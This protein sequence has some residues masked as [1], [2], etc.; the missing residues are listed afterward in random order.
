MAERTYG[1]REVS[2]PPIIHLTPQGI[3]TKLRQLNPRFSET[4]RP[5][6]IPRLELSD[7]LE[8]ASP[9]C[10]LALSGVGRLSKKQSTAIV[11]A[12]TTRKALKMEDI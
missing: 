3:L 7:R 11:N 6:G 4:F 5:L 2:D 10:G 1:A 8:I 9:S 12:R